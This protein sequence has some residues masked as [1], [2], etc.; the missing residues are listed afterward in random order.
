MEEEI[1]AAGIHQALKRGEPLNRAIQS[2]INAGYSREAVDKAVKLVNSSQDLSLYTPLIP[3]ARPGMKL[4]PDLPPGFVPASQPQRQGIQGTGRGA[5]SAE[6][7]QGQMQNQGIKKKRKSHLGLWLLVILIIL[8][9][10]AVN[11]FLVW[12]FLLNR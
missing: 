7:G 9:T 4:Q 6:R 11:A 2:F 10:V 12:K 8:I 1:I 5:G 3:A